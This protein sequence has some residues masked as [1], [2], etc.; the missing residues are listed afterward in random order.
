MHGVKRLFAWMIPRFDK[1]RFNVSL[2]SLRRKDL[3]D[4]TLEAVRDRRHLPGAAQ[5]RS[6][7]PITAL[8]KVLQRQAAPTS[9]TCTATAR[10]RSGG[11]ARGGWAFR[12]S[13]TST[14]ITATRRGSRRSPTGCWRRTPI[15]RSRS[16]SRRREFT[17]RA[18]LMPAERTKVVYLGAPLDEFARPRSADEIAAARAGA[19][20][21]AGHDRHR[22][23]HAA[24]A[25]E[26]QSST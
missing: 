19:G 5:V 11:C 3:S 14:P 6:R 7:R 18:R 8:L 12:R 20:H 9:C 1:T 26:G 4:D 24:D 22:H 23:H 10:R 15:W 16:R 25:V 2:I 17:T 21:R 13:C